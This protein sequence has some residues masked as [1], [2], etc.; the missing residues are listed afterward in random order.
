MKFCQVTEYTVRNIFIERPYAKCVG[1][2]S[3]TPSSKKIKI[4]HIFGSTISTIWITLMDYISIIY[5]LYVYYI[6]KNTMCAVSLANH[7]RAV[8]D[9]F[10][11]LRTYQRY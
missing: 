8:T 7:L 1:E 5:I 4:K 9:A 2:T 11:S 6:C 10:R 3:T